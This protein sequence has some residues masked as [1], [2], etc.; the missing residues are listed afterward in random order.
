M[1]IQLVFQLDSANFDK[2]YVINSKILKKR[3]QKKESMKVK[4]GNKVI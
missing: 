4:L 2:M 1:S 3:K